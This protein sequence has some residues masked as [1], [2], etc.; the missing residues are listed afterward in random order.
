M[1]E[2]VP[3]YPKPDR[4]W[5][6]VEKYKVTIFY[7]A[8]TVIRA[9]E[10]EGDDWPNNRDLNSLRLLG[11]V[12]EPINPEAWLWYYNVI[13]KGKCPI[14]DT[15]WQT[16]TGGIMITPLP[17]AMVLKP[18]SATFP[19]P[20]IVADVLRED[21]TKSDVDQGGSLVIRKPWPGMLRTVWG[22]PERYKN[23]YYGKYP[24]LY[25][26]GDGAK[27]DGEDYLWLMG[28]I[29]D[30]INVSGHRIGTAE[31]ESAMV[32]NP[33]VAEAAVVPFPH[34]IKGQALYAFVILKANIEKN[35]ELKKELV[36]HVAEVIGHIAKPDK[37]QFANALPKT[38]SGKI[39]RR[40][41]KAIAEGK[42][43]V[44][45]ITTL[46]NPE[47]VEVLKQERVQ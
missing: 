25:F 34:K 6:I 2:G 20:G 38:R 44:G 37:I 46:A 13:G 39:M 33:K 47:V 21:G 35:D 42:E 14:V 1:F 24:G 43:D 32:S 23:T 9:L 26:T 45:N 29:D 10:K 11:T 41:L 36:D 17:G 30:V 16:E 15:W 40:I 19:F 18:G 12:G 27:V 28:R 3:N 31:V 4:F 8:P 7:T 22:N 5:E